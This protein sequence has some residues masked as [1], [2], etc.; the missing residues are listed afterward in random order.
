MSWFSSD[1]SGKDSPEDIRQYED[2]VRRAEDYQGKDKQERK[3]LN[4]ATRQAAKKV[5]RN[6]W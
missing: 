3:R 2:A 5:S 4:E 6:R 1:N